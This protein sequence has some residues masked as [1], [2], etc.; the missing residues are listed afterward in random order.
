MYYWI[1][2]KIV[3]KENAHL[4]IHELAFLR[5]FGIFD[6]MQV[7]HDINVF[8]DDY[9]ERFQHSADA[10]GLTIP[11]T[12]YELKAEARK[13]AQA[14]KFERSGMKLILT[15]GYSEDGFTP[16]PTSNLY[17]TQQPFSAPTHAQYTQGI[18][19]ITHEYRREIPGVK[20]LSYITPILLLPKIKA[21]NASDVLYHTNGSISESSRSN[22]F[23][24][25]ENGVLITPEKDVLHGVT[26][27]QILKLAPQFVET[28][29]GDITLADLRTAREAFM[30]SSTKG[31]LPITQID[32]IQIGN[33]KVG[34]LA[35]LLMQAFQ[36][37]TTQ[38]L[39][40]HMA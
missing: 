7:R 13:L 16:A 3:P 27:K 33:G 14:N 9:L 32:E 18:K 4:H 20:T 40:S 8:F 29:I 31:V 5:G 38:Y 39:T 37:L 35:P 36:D 26:R 21:A 22:F 34:S 19:L 24:L 2:G 10:M 6:F 1:N 30:T 11:L 25:N 12:M 28:R 17:M 23:I 15:G